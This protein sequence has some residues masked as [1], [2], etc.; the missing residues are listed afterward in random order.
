MN[1][2]HSAYPHLVLVIGTV[3]AAIAMLDGIFAAGLIAF[4]KWNEDAGA[5][6]VQVGVSCAI[7]NFTA[8]LFL[9]FTKWMLS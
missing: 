5:R 6:V 1:A 8:I 3:T 2:F 7:G 9:A 4:G